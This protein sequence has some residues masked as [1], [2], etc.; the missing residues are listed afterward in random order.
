MTTQHHFNPPAL[1]IK[2][3]TPNHQVP[4]GSWEQ[5]TQD[6]P[7]TFLILLRA[8]RTH[9][10][11]GEPPSSASS[12]NV[13]AAPRE[14]VLPDLP[15]PRLNKPDLFYSKCDPGLWSVGFTKI[16]IVQMKYF[17]LFYCYSFINI[18][19]IEKE[20][21]IFKKRVYYKNNKKDKTP[22]EKAW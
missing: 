4:P 14:W 17:L 18:S 2:S 13:P 8:L 3:R 11:R 16:K 10:N 6:S 1:G 5:P 19:F 7:T 15:W 21:G 20:K 9:P 22:K 12:H